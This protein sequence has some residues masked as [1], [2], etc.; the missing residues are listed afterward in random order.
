MLDEARHVHVVEADRQRDVDQWVLNEADEEGHEPGVGGGGAL[1]DTEEGDVGAE[2]AVDQHEDHP[3]QHFHPS[4]DRLMGL[5]GHRKRR[6]RER[7][8][9]CP[10]RK[11]QQDQA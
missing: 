9:L 11:G 3:A 1:Q 4:C 2:E 7:Q 6:R 8:A 10:T 5:R